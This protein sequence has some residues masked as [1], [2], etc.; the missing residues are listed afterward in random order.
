[1]DSRIGYDADFLAWTEEQAR[2]PADALPVDCPYT[3]DLL[4]N[5]D[6]WPINRHGL[7]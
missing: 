4:L 3:L 2:M 5:D 1:M 6:W 7:A